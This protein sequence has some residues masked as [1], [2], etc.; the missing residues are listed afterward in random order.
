MALRYKLRH[1]MSGYHT[2]SISCI[3]FSPSGAHL[4]SCGIDGRLCAWMVTNGHPTFVISSPV[5]FASLV[6]LSEGLMLAGRQDGVIVSVAI[7]EVS[8]IN[9]TLCILISPATRKLCPQ[10]AF[11]PITYLLSILLYQ[12]R[13]PL[14]P[15]RGIKFEY[16]NIRIKVCISFRQYMFLIHSSRPADQTEAPRCATNDW[17]ESNRGGS[18]DWA[19]LD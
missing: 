8:A 16:G 13:E 6:W 4:A 3:S 17:G 7:T 11:L 2:D 1:K 19:T 10:P 5:G 14:Q 9:L 12:R 15:Q 18:G